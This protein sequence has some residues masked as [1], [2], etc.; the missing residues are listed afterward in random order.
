MVILKEIIAFLNKEVEGYIGDIQQIITGIAPL[1]NATSGKITYC[2]YIDERSIPLLQKTQA[3]V[4]ASS[5]IKPKSDQFAQK[6][7]IFT[8]NPRESFIRVATE[9]FPPPRK[10]GIHPS[11]LIG[12]A[13]KIG[14]NVYI[15]KYV[16]IGDNV[17]I[18]E[19]TIINDGV[20]LYD[21]VVI[22]S[23]CIIHAGAVIGA[24]GFGFERS[25]N[26]QMLKFPHYASVHI[27]NNVEI[28]ANTCID[29]GTLSDTIIENGVKI[30]NLCH[31]AH[32]TVIGEDSV[33]IA[34][35]LVG[36]STK[37]GKRSWVAP[38]ACLKNGITLGDDA[39]I[40]LGAVVLKDVPE[41]VTV[42]GVPAKPLEKKNIKPG[43]SE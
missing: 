32:N 40:G 41:K 18:G 1:N 12:Q 31:I 29:R 7:V 15:G 11:A 3:I 8:Q 33:I 5:E 28:G 6:T 21:N 22:G 24:D 20:H 4:I 23:D 36:G 42:V 27:G 10:K 34:L 26:G 25:E 35:S 38:C 39:F 37:V 16:T 14:V 30:D 2:K 17:V 9:F 43:K 19:N 13:C